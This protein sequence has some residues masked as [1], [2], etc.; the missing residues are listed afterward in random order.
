MNDGTREQRGFS[1]AE[2]MIVVIILG[3][4]AAIV[5][6]AFSNS[7][8]D[9]N[10]NVCLENLRM[11]QAA[12]TLERMKA[13]VFPASAT[14]LDEYLRTP[15]VCPL[16]GSYAWTLSDDAYHIKC[17]AQHTPA[18]N[19]VCIHEDQAPTAK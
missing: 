3:I 13:G 5:V 7:S 15:P 1:L 6:A 4:L 2:L 12:L 19:H 16:G 10:L 18:S 11:I 9:A 14:G 17:S 8:S